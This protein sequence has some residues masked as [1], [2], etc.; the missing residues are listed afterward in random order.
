MRNIEIERKLRGRMIDPSLLY[1]P[2]FWEC[3]ILTDT[4]IPESIYEVKNDHIPFISDF[5]RNGLPKKRVLDFEEIK[6][7]IEKR[8]LNVFSVRENIENVPQIFLEG[9]HAIEK[10]K[11]R[12]PINEI[13]IDEFVFLTTKSCLL[14]RLKKVFKQFE[15]ANALPLINLEK[16]FLKNGRTQFLG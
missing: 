1:T 8:N 4:Y 14:S 3:E 9:L 10:S 15:K 16:R 2:E 6:E 13:L 7:N 12:Y 5:Y 11:F